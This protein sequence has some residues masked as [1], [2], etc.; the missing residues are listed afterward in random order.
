M[1][2][3]RRVQETGRPEKV[4]GLEGHRFVGQEACCEG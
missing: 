4:E 1:R 3:T 2:L